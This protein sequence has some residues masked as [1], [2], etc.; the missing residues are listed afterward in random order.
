[1]AFLVQTIVCS[2][3]QLIRKKIYLIW[4]YTYWNIG[5]RFRLFTGHAPISISL[6]LC[7]MWEV[8]LLTLTLS[9]TLKGEL[10]FHGLVSSSAAESTLERNE[11]RAAPPEK[12]LINV[13]KR[14]S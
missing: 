13:I 6:A 4:K 12:S 5:W 11:S 14:D 10:S 7:T 2:H 9:L 1:L 8:V 3:S